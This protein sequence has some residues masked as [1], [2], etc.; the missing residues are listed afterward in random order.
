MNDYFEVF[1]NS[2]EEINQ[3]S[4]EQNYNLAFNHDPFSIYGSHN[5]SLNVSDPTDYRLELRMDDSHFF[6]SFKIIDFS[7]E[8]YEFLAKVDIHRTI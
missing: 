2:Y 1:V 7:T 6:S 4:H 3:W 8:V 5:L